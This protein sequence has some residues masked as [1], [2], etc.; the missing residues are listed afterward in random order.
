MVDAVRIHRTSLLIRK[1]NQNYTGFQRCDKLLLTRVSI[2]YAADWSEVCTAL[3]ESNLSTSVEI[4]NQFPLSIR[5]TGE[6]V[7]AIH[8][9]NE[10]THC[11]FV[12]DSE[13]LEAT[14]TP[15]SRGLAI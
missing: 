12:C 10:R 7:R 13:I 2:S 8:R 4:I 15:I 11:S 6:F 5:S 3:R 9:E 14:Q 1:A